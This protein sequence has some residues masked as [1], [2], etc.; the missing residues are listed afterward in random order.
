MRLKYFTALLLFCTPV[1]WA[2]E[3]EEVKPEDV[4]RFLDPTVMINSFDYSFTANFVPSSIQVYSFAREAQTFPAGS[5]PRTSAKSFRFSS[6][7]RANP[8]VDKSGGDGLSAPRH[9]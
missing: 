3:K 7:R 5:T 1:A 4:K 6:N 8:C 2:Q 9:W